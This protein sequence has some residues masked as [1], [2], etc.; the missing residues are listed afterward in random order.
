MKQPKQAQSDNDL[1]V[2]NANNNAVEK[3]CRENNVRVAP[4]S[5]WKLQYLD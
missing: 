1:I 4:S 3:Y 2:M 5:I